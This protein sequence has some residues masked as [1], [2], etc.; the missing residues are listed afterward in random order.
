MS[1]VLSVCHLYVAEIYKKRE[2]TTTTMMIRGGE[3][4]VKENEGKARIEK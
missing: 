1:L 4:N 2:A 3:E